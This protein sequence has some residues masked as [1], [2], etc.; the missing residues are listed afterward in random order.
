M[1]V[2]VLLFIAPSMELEKGISI[3]DKEEA[4]SAFAQN[5]LMP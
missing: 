4:I 2:V 5:Q 3:D 1:T